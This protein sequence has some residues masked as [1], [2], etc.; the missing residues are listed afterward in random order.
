MQVEY[1]VDLSLENSGS[2]HILKFWAALTVSH[3][4]ARIHTEDDQDALFLVPYAQCITFHGRELLFRD[5]EKY[6]W[7]APSNQ[8]M[9]F[10]ITGLGNSIPNP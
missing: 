5:M 6:F 2:N 3:A 1:G 9:I 7:D 8:Q 4:A 10:A